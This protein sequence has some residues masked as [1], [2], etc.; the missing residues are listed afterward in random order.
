MKN[1]NNE[2]EKSKI[3]FRTMLLQ[4]KALWDSTI[5]RRNNYFFSKRKDF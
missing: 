4:I 5:Q 3:F 1:E 2:K